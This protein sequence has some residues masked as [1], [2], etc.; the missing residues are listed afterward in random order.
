MI[1]IYSYFT[2]TSNNNLRNTIATNPKNAI[3]KITSI[4]YRRGMGHTAYYE[5]ILDNKKVFSQTLNR[6][7]GK[8]GDEICVK[9]LASNP[10]KNIY[11]HEKELESLYS[12]GFLESLKFLG[13]MIAVL[14]IYILGS[15][16]FGNK[17]LLAEVTSRT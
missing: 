7:D 13:M 10:N 9:Y 16:A 1:L 6:Y 8:V 14:P 17:K 2:I 5:F 15:I 4:H 12:D 3:A 11:C